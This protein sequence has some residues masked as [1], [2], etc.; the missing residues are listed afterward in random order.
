VLRSQGLVLSAKERKN[1]NPE[2]LC[3]LLGTTHCAR[4]NRRK[5]SAVEDAVAVKTID[6]TKHV[7]HLARSLVVHGGAGSGADLL[8][9][10]REGTTA[11]VHYSGAGAAAAVQEIDV[12]GDRDPKV[13]EGTVTKIDRRRRQITIR[14]DSATSETFQL[15]ERAAT[16][17]GPDIAGEAAETGRVT[18]FYAD[19][20]DQKVAHYFLKTS[21]H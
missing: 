8:A 14:F 15:T 10:L 16:D 6:G 4:G 21:S 5:G 12:V 3:A 19:Q 9:G 20:G 17:G 1:V 2:F 18:V 13:T 11:V 7:L